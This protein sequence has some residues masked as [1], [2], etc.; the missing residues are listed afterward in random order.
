[1]NIAWVISHL[2]N[3]NCEKS[4]KCDLV[5]IEMGFEIEPIFGTKR[6]AVNKKNGIF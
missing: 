4:T 2:L 5:K 6:S 3:G 1:M